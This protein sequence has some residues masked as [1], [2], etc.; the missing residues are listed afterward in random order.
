VPR[1]HSPGTVSV[2]SAHTETGGHFAWQLS[3]FAGPHGNEQ[4]KHSGHLDLC[5]LCSEE[6]QPPVPKQDT[7]QAL[8]SPHTTISATEQGTVISDLPR[9]FSGTV[10]PCLRRSEG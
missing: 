6:Q 1:H 3:T 8:P 2:H 4:V 7:D 9:S 5:I 10:H